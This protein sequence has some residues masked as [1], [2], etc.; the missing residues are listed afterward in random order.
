MLLILSWWLVIQLFTLATLPLAS[1]LFARLPSRGYPL[2]K[3]LGLLLVSYLLWLG[4][5]LHVLPNSFGGAVVAL[6]SWRAFPRG[7]AAM[8]G[9]GMP[10]VCVRWSAG[11]GEL[12]D[13]ADR[14]AALR[15]SCWPLGRVPGLQPRHRR[16][17]E[18]D[19]VRLRQ[20]HPPQ[21][22]LPAAGSWLSGYGISS[23]TSATSCSRR[24][25]T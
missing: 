11:C 19:G 4:A 3:A 8:D 12:A 25:P 14:R 7:W 21:P 18:A 6:L 17:R 22:P 13:S 1:R 24:S 9:S 2:A 5:T 15:C 16:H 23:T 20:R 10:V